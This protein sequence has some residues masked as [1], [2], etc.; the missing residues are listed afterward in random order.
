[1]KPKL[2]IFDLIRFDR[3]AGLVGEQSDFACEFGS[4]LVLVTWFGVPTPH[5][6]LS[7]PACSR[8]CCDGVVGSGVCWCG[9][10]FILFYFRYHSYLQNGSDHKWC[11][12]NFVQARAMKSAES[13]RGQLQN[14]MVRMGLQLVSTE[15]TSKDY[16]L[17][18]RKALVAGYFMQVCPR[19][20]LIWVTGAAPGGQS[21]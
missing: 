16:Y 2:N 14:I 1:M 9:G 17:N 15:F 21:R 6:F 3:L 18:I 4:N 11:Y 13:V 20:C 7:V 10:D 8:G 19:I 12:D 5:L